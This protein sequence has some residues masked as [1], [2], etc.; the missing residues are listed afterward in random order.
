MT[1]NFA[2]NPAEITLGG[3]W[4]QNYPQYYEKLFQT[5]IICGEINKIQGVSY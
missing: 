1:F 3:I 4:L 5:L 2:A